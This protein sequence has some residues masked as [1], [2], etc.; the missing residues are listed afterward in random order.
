MDSA[1]L[2][3]K[4]DYL[5]SEFTLRGN[6]TTHWETAK[7]D[8]SAWFYADAIYAYGHWEGNYLI[9]DWWPEGWLYDNYELDDLAVIPSIS[10]T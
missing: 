8:D 2:Y 9:R 7:F 1:L 6:L 3:P 5:N 4:S 10:P